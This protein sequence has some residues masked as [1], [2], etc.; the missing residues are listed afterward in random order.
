M[1]SAGERVN[2]GT[3]TLVLGGTEE[4]IDVRGEAPLVQADTGERSFT[5]STES[6]ENL[7]IANR[8]FTALATLA[9][10]VSGMSRIGGGGTTVVMLD[11]ISA[12]DD[13]AS[14]HDETF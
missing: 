8:S 5:I 3:L 6:L 7:P 2:A 12:I 4:V 13:N 9:P 10:G 1:F 14:F 11:G